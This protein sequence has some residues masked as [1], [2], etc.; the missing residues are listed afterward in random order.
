MVA[1]SS[2]LTTLTST[3]PGVSEPTTSWPRAFSFTRATKSRTTGSATSASSSAMRT[4]RIMSDT[5]PS[6]MRAWP[7][8]SLTMRESFSERAEAMMKTGWTAT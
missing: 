6:V 5:L 3:C 7:R 2:R 1:A 4:S 8:I